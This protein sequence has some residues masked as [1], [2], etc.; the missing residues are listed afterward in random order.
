MKVAVF[1]DTRT[2]SKH[3]GCSLVMQNLE[4]LLK[5]ANIEPVWYWPVGRDWRACLTQLPEKGSVDGVIVNGEGTIH[6]SESSD[7]ADMLAD[8]AAYATEH[9]NVP[10]FLINATLFKN[11]PRLYKKLSGFSKIFVRDSL[12][13]DELEMNGLEGRMVPDLTFAVQHTTLKAEGVRAG[14]GATDSVSSLVSQDIQSASK[15]H[16]WDFQPM[17]L[18]QPVE[19]N[20]GDIL[21]P[22]RLGGKFKRRLRQQLYVQ[23]PALSSSD[24]FID[25]LRSKRMVI[26]GRYHTV[27]LCV[28]T[29]TPFVAVESNTPKISALLRDIFGTDRRV[30][31][32]VAGLSSTELAMY[33]KYDEAECTAIST[34]LRRASEANEKMISDIREAMHIAGANS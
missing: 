21:S 13:R 31:P 12:S 1:N 24:E 30:V 5:G 11:S 20:L 6:H 17:V 19:F 8:I 2:G 32:G 25:W 34:F 3:F 16:G 18:P 10:A 9:L 22:I 7:R 15:R 4:T 14:L 23:R 29:G 27:T 33:Q 26:T 28:V